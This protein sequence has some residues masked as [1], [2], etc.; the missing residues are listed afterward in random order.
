MA[1]MIPDYG[2]R[3]AQEIKSGAERRVYEALKDG[4]PDDYTA[5][6]SVAWVAR[7]PGEHAQDGE[8]DFMLVHP[9]DG[10]LVL[11]V[12]GGGVSLDGY[13]G[14]WESRDAKGHHHA[15]KNP[16]GQAKNAKYQILSFLR[17]HRDWD[18]LVSG[19]ICIGHAVW[20]PDI[21]SSEKIIGPDRPR[22]L[23]LT[24]A[25]LSDVRQAIQ[26]AW[27][28]SGASDNTRVEPGKNAVALVGKIFARSFT[29][30]PPAAVRI[31]EEERQRVELTSIQFRVL[32]MLG[33][34]RRVGIAGGAGTGKT[35]LAL[36]KAHELAR[37][38]FKTL[39]LAFNRPLGDHLASV[40]DPALPITAAS[41][42]VFAESLFR[43][44]GE[45]Y[46]SRAK[47][48]YPGANHW[49]VIVPAALHYLADEN[50][51]VRFDAILV[52]EAQDFADEFWLPLESMM[53]DLEKTPL[54][55]FYDTNQRIYRRSEKFPIQTNDEFTLTENCRNTAAIH[56]TVR[57]L[58]SGSELNA[59]SIGGVPVTWHQAQTL[60]EQTKLIRAMVQKMLG[61]GALAVGDLIVLIADPFLVNSY[62]KGLAHG[63]ALPGGLCFE[64]DTSNARGR[65]RVS[66]AARFKGLEAA[67]VIVCGVDT[68]DPEEDEGRMALY[69][70]FSRPKSELH[71]VGASAALDRIQALQRTEERALEVALPPQM[72]H[73]SK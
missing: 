2:S 64:E 36:E 55:L 35:L 65:I 16:F 6:H 37:R 9:K 69:V 47:R 46:M 25:D 33:S 42:H 11:E 59:P 29:V 66:T 14:Q 56:A 8:A 1:K 20:F 7:Q 54:Y 45:D 10:I 43:K 62:V 34:R 23:I 50:E 26:R 5:L 72:S 51:E 57:P 31:S 39:L 17:Q 28:F 22:E 61:D 63:G 19:R 41:F 38:G 32:K 58:F 27:Q 30:P 40:V 49:N 70:A 21:N 12:K 15:I 3:I 48:D 13:S 4:L 73:P 44:F 67:V 24:S 18:R 68:L 60:T 52:D 53:G 71:I